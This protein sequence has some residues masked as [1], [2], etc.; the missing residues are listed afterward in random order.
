MSLALLLQFT[1]QDLVDRH[2]ASALGALWSF[3]LPLV[4]ILIF[5]LIFSNIMGAKLQ[6]AGLATLGQYSYSVYLITAL[7]AWNCFA[8]TTT[9]LTNIFHEKAGLITK[10]KLSIF[11]LPLFVP[12]T[13]TIL[14]LISMVFFGTFLLAIGFEWTIAWLW[15]P[16]IFITQQLLAYA[17]GFICAVLSVFIRDIKEFVGILMQLWFWMTPIV[18]VPGIIPEQW[19]SFLTLNPYYHIAQS[20]RDT[21]ITGVS[22]SLPPLI[23]ILASAVTLL[24]FGYWLAKRLERD[25]RDF[26]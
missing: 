14:Y 10:V 19:Q 2:A 17:I 6:M 21:M 13:E 12:L 4:N 9:R 1:R 7:L 22:P 15:W 18:Y 20:L 3:I 23:L 26:L 25:I 8:S 5:T 24:L 16:F 11:S